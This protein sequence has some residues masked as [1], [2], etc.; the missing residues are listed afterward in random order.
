MQQRPPTTWALQHSWTRHCESQS[1]D[2]RPTQASRRVH[3]RRS[4]QRLDPETAA[5]GG[6]G[7]VGGLRWWRVD[8]FTGCH[9]HTSRER[10]RDR[11]ARGSV[12]AREC[13][14]AAMSAC[15]LGWTVVDDPPPASS[16]LAPGRQ[17]WPMGPC[18]QRAG[19]QTRGWIKGSRD[20]GSM[21]ARSLGRSTATASRSERG[22]AAALG[23]LQLA[24]LTRRRPRSQLRRS[25][26]LPWR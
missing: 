2:L 4:T 15:Q 8:S 24:V 26:A 19:A 16:G 12:C 11:A 13:L 22:D 9:D 5:P 18:P 21:G 14:R 20:R 25:G 6:W 1:C 10:L 23:Q 17:A 7:P 3:V